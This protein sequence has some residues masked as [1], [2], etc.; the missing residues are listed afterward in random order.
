MK[1]VFYIL[2]IGKGKYME[3]A[4]SA[5]SQLRSPM[6]LFFHDTNK[7]TFDIYTNKFLYSVPHSLP[8]PAFLQ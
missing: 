1:T 4:E 8:N 2:Q 7:C 5:E 6:T 3:A